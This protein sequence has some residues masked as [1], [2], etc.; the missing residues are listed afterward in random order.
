VK[1]VLLFCGTDA[2][3]AAFA[4]LTPDEL[5]ERYSQVGRW[6][7]T[8]RDKIKYADQLQEPMTATTVRH[9][10]IGPGEPVVT[11]GPFIEAKE[12]VGGYASIEVA[13]LDEALRMAKSW[14]GRGSVEIRPVV[15]MMEPPRH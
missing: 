4:A 15:V 5:R 11:D 10:R 8:H 3:A 13:D 9:D 1:Y 2:D 6:F 12:Q 14:P 7:E